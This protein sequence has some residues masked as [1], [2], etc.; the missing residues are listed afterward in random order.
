ML[1][2]CKYCKNLE[3]DGQQYRCKVLDIPKSKETIEAY[4]ECYEFQY[5]YRK[6]G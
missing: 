5:T 4:K 3:P 1:I 2:M 6:G